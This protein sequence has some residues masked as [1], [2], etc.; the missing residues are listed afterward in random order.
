M[1]DDIL[2]GEFPLFGEEAAFLLGE[3]AVFRGEAPLLGVSSSGIVSTFN[4]LRGATVLLTPSSLFSSSFPGLAVEG[5]S[6]P[7]ILLSPAPA[8][9]LLALDPAPI[10]LAGA[11]FL[12][13]LS[14]SLGYSFLVGTF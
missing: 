6:P 9:I 5:L 8:P 7:P 12:S 2:V 4:G 14:S 13:V 1:V 11:S 10:L 3:A